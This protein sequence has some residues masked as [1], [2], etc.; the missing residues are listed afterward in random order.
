MWPK[1][2]ETQFS[3][4]NPLKVLSYV[5]YSGVTSQLYIPF[6]CVQLVQ[7]K[8][9]WMH[10]SHRNNRIKNASGRCTIQE[11]G[12]VFCTVS[13]ISPKPVKRGTNSQVHSTYHGTERL[14]G[15]STP[16]NRSCCGGRTRFI[17]CVLTASCVHQHATMDVP[18]Y[19]RLFVR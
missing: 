6:N 16:I 8:Q 12:F 13:F 5:Q 17:Q 14:F 19:E 1:L 7:S 4:L 15:S 11:S 2:T 9:C 18:N 10:K 3:I